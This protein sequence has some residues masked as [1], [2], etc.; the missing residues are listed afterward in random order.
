MLTISQI[1][2]FVLVTVLSVG[3]IS[4]KQACSTP[5]DVVEDYVDKDL[6]LKG[7]GKVIYSN[8]ATI[9]ELCKDYHSDPIGCTVMVDGIQ[10]A[11]V[12]DTLTGYELY[13]TVAHEKQ[14]IVQGINYLDRGQVGGVYQEFPA[15]AYGY[16]VAN[17]FC[18]GGVIDAS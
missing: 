5:V 17:K 9:V 11:H 2:G 15:Y 16:K 10:E 4:T 12:L 13:A 7:Y 18:L 8:K 6:N 3:C 1:T 14:H